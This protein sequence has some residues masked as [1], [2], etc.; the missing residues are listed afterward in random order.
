MHALTPAQVQH[1]QRRVKERMTVEDRGYSS[2]CWIS[3]RAQQGGGYTKLGYLGKTL[4]THRVAYAVFVGPI[5]DGKVID[6]LCRQTA[7]CNP[8]HLEPVTTQVNLLRGVGFVAVQ[9]RRTH[10]P[11]GH[12]LVGD[13][14]YRR[15]GDDNRR[16]CR[17]CRNTYRHWRAV[18]S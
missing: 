14:V 6:H 9:A 1:L 7:C 4:L 13:N 5:P 16:E 8:A 3:S 12:A 18:A 17:T 15:P 11:R 10:C 2:P